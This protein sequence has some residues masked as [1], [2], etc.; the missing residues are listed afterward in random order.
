[1]NKFEL[2]HQWLILDENTTSELDFRLW[3]D[4]PLIIPENTNKERHFYNQKLAIDKYWL[5]VPWGMYM[6]KAVDCLRHWWNAKFPDNKLMTFRLKIWD[7]DFA[8]A[9]KKKHSLVVWYRT[10]P[11]YYKD[12]QDDGVVIWEDFPKNWGHLV[13]TNFLTQAIKIDDNY[14]GTKKWNT[15]TNNK[16]AK[17]QKNWVFFPSAYLFLYD[18]SMKDEIRDK[19]DLDGAKDAFDLWIYNWLDSRKPVSRQEVAVMIMRWIWLIL[20]L[21]SKI[22]NTDY[23]LKDLDKETK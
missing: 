20:K 16:I 14:F 13:R 2:E 15:Y 18:T 5:K 17:L 3:S 1:M 11:E 8:E 12:S 4:N 22:R 21:L 9:L 10:S 19:I 7:D 23:S 6:H